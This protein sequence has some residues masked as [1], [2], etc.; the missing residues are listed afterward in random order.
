[1]GAA[2]QIID[3]EGRIVS[4]MAQSDEALTELLDLYEGGRLNLTAYLAEIRS[5]LARD[6]EFIDG[7]VHL[8]NALLDINKVRPAL[9][10]Y[11]KAIAIGEAVITPSFAGSLPWLD[12]NNRPFLRAFKGAIT[13]N[14]R[15]NR[16]RPAIALLERL[17]SLNPADEQN[18]LFLLG[19]LY[20]RSKEPEKA[21]FLL[22]SRA[23]VYPPCA[24]DLALLAFMRG[25]HVEAATQLRRAFV[26]NI[27]IAEMLCG[28]PSPKPLAIFHDTNFASPDVAHDYI[29]DGAKLWDETCDALPFLHWLYHHPSVMAERAA[30]LDCQEQLLWEQDVLRRLA[31]IERRRLLLVE[32][33]ER[34]SQE[35]VTKRSTKEGRIV[36]PWWRL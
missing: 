22:E 34:I 23:S 17:H 8:G 15:L 33:D 19:S 5:I 7:H 31:I 18:L 29:S 11:S 20:L 4:E 24:Y 30:L 3:D 27:Y 26:A 32:I 28:H 13:A 6:P 16:R 25:R 2:F 36:S 9:A 21:R 14:R 35:I 10:A 1:M 12:S